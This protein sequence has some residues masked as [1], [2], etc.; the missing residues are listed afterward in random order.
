LLSCLLLFGCGEKS[1]TE[2]SQSASEKPTPPNGSTEPAADTAQPS[3]DSVTLPLSDADVERLLKEAVDLHSTEERDGLLYLPNESE[4]FSGWGK[5]MYDSGQV[6]SL[7]KAKDGEPDG[8]F[9]WWHEN[10]QKAAE[11]ALINNREDGLHTKWDESGS[12]WQEGNWKNGKKDGLWTEWHENSRKWREF[13]YKDG[14]K[15]GL[16]ME[17]HENGNINYEMTYKEGIIGG[18][19]KKWHENGRKYVEEIYQDDQVNG[20]FTEW[21]D[22]GQKKEEGTLKHGRKVPE[23]YWNSKGEEVETWQEAEE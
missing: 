9:T 11:G 16:W 5:K 18:T 6:K 3:D 4:P 22:N 13:I 15:D 10:G 20:L 23:K 19:F 8:P 14:E 12:K 7:G 17:W 1:S 21:H 2:G